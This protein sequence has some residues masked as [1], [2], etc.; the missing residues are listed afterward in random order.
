MCKVKA[1]GSS[2]ME[3]HLAY[4]PEVQDLIVPLSLTLGEKK[5]NI[6]MLQFRPAK[7]AK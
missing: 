5:G 3:E 6:K 2:T 7:A 4:H 1:N